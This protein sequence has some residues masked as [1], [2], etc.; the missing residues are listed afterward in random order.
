MQW[1]GRVRSAS[2]GR[3]TLLGIG[4]TAMGTVVAGCQRAP[5]PAP[6]PAP[7]HGPG[8]TPS[9]EGHQR[10]IAEPQPP[11]A[12]VLSYDLRPGIHGP[13]GRRAVRRMLATWTRALRD[14][15]ADDRDRRTATV[16]VG[17]NLFARLGLHAPQ[18]LRE[19]P[20]FA[21]D[22]LRPEDGGGDVCVQVC[23][24]TPDAVGELARG[25]ERVGAGVLRPRWR[26]AGFLPAT[27]P[28]QTPRN[29]LGF[30]DGTAN[31]TVAEAARWVW[32]GAGPYRGGT[33]LV[34]RR[35]RLATGEFAELPV[36][37]QERIIGRHKDGGGPLQGGPEH[38][39]ADLFA[40]T[41]QGRYLLPADAHVRLA[42]PRFD[43][44]ARMMRRG[45]SYD[46]GPDDRGLLFL[47]YLADPELFVRV[48]RR[49]AAHDALNPYIEHYGS[50]VFYVLPGW[51]GKEVLGGTVL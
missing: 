28:G 50:A 27:R 33:Y 45:Y 2:P 7:A 17:R 25:L 40:K 23:A 38:T 42:H 43:G 34:V 1:T 3:R 26:Q 10:G 15:P 20:A 31:P 46:N 11:Y 13:E 41:P 8:R 4:L 36:E 5:G 24:R 29:L 16:G 30:K 32:L 35:I 12:L 14:L 18:A 44:G 19:L 47:A 39:E 48:Q 37:R 21:G 22:R 6:A 51:S 9:P 49:L